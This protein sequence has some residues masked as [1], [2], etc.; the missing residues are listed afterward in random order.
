MTL[1]GDKA[2]ISYDE[3]LQM[4]RGEILGLKGSVDFYGSSVKELRVEFKKSLDLY[5]KVCQEEGITPYKNNISTLIPLEVIEE[6]LGSGAVMEIQDY[7]K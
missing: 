2:L 6:V 4:F 5:L 7:L 1:R 3:E